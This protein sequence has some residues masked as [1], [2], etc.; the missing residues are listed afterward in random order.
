MATDTASVVLID[1]ILT[2]LQDEE[3]GLPAALTTYGLPAV[4]QW[5]FGARE[6]VAI[7]NSPQIE[8]DLGA[9]PQKGA[10]GYVQRDDE[11]I[12]IAQIAS[13]DE[14]SLHRYLIGY[15]DVICGVLETIA[16]PKI[17]V[18]DIDRGPQ[19]SKGNALFRSVAVVG[20]IVTA[21]N[22]G[23]I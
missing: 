20:K 3:T 7:T 21:R 18:V 8:V 10:V 16:A 22:R 11:L 9:G 5:C 12:V 13:G 4:K 23:D 17:A 15:A 2:A 1:A 14:E 19:M 6:L